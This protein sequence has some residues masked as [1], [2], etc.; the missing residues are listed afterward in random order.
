MRVRRTE[1]GAV[2]QSVGDEPAGQTAS[3]VLRCDP[4]VVDVEAVVALVLDRDVG[5]DVS[6]VCDAPREDILVAGRAIA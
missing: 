3:T 6:P 2:S 5:D 1:L 4:E